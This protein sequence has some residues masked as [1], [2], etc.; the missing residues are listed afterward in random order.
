MFIYREVEMS[1]QESV[2]CFFFYFRYEDKIKCLKKKKLWKKLYIFYT[3]ALSSWFLN[4]AFY[5]GDEYSPENILFFF[6]ILAVEYII[7]ASSAW[8]KCKIE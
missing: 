1:K 7:I 6:Q 8:L 5:F 2:E 3:V 4:S